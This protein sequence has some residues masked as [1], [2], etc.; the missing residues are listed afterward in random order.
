[1]YVTCLDNVFVKY[2]KQLD[3]WV[4]IS[5]KYNCGILSFQLRLQ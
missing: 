2:N 3:T 1:M 5:V 4:Y